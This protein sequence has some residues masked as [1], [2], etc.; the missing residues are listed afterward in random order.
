MTN[1]ELN[2]IWDSLFDAKIAFE[3]M[4]ELAKAGFPHGYKKGVVEHK[5]R[6][7]EKA[8][9]AFDIELRGQGNE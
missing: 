8:L 3:D 1:K 6:Q 7:A 4:L 9:N 5:L 2:L